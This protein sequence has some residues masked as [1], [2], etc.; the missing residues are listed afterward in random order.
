MIVNLV[1]RHAVEELVSKLKS[2]KTIAKEQVI[3]ESTLARLH[4]VYICLPIL[5]SEKQS[6]RY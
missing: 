4:N 5:V 3:R 1:K 2:G 6:R